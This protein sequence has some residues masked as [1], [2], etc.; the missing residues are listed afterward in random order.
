MKVADLVSRYS[1]WI[2]RRRIA[3]MGLVLGALLTLAS[4]AGR[5]GFDTDYRIWFEH[6]DPY[7]AQHDRFLKEFGN[8]DSFV[9]AFED[10][11]GVLRPPAIEAIQRLTDKLWHVRGVNRV[12]SLTNF[13]A[14]R[15]V[16]DGISVEDL[17]PAGPVT[18]EAIA[19]AQA[20]IDRDPLIVGSLV[21]KNR[22]VGVIRAKFAP[23][24][25]NP[26]LPAAVY[27]QL[28]ALLKEET[29]RSGY[30]FHIA[31]GPITDV[32]F[33]QVA[34]GDM[35]R[36]MPLLLLVM[37]CVLA[38]VFFSV[39]AVLIPVVVGLL[40]IVAVMGLNGLLGIK[41]D[42]VTAS[43]PQLLL[44]ISVA[45]VMHML[46]SFFE[47]KRQGSSSPDAARAAIDENATAML[48]TN[49]ATALG[50]ASFMVGNIV[51]VTRLGFMACVGSALITLLALTVVPALLSYYPRSAPRSPLLRL[52]LGSRFQRL[53]AWVCARPKRVIGTWVGAVV[54]AA[55]CM[56]LLVV[57]S[58]PTGYFKE[59]HWFRDSIDFM[60][61]RGSGGA[62]YEIVVRGKGPD[63]VKTVAYM[64]DLEA[65]TQ[66]LGH[67]APGDFRNVY[68]LSTIVRNLNRA[69]HED[70][71][72][73]HTVPT[74]N[75]EIA[76]YLLL[77]TLSVPVGQDIND[78]MNVDS[79]ASRITVIRPLVSTRVSRT[80]IDAIQA[81]AAKNLHEVKIEFTGRDVLYTNMGNNLTDS[82]VGSIAWDIAV[83]LP[84][85]LLMFRTVTASIVSVFAN[86][87]P[88]VI[89]M[90]F[91]ALAHINL[92]VGTLMVAGLG[93]GIAVDDTVHLLA[94]YYRYR[95]TGAPARE[96]AIGTMSHVGMPATLTTITL[97]LSF[98]V[99]S[100]AEFLP[101]LYFGL[102][103]SMVI[104]LALLAD[105]TLTPALL[106][107]I[108]GRRDAAQRAAQPSA[109]SEPTPA[110]PGAQPA[111]SALSA[112]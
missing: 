14:A 55:A 103:I 64:R 109:A 42:S 88:L 62:V 2:I 10:E 43:L 94:H 61:E 69:L 73:F 5:I 104:A 29:A 51:P 19:R 79:S 102:L 7:L 45:T 75:E 39:W 106:S 24:A 3:V 6:D 99:F 46:A 92:D 63:A 67:E 96:A 18:P 111:A 33:D 16:S 4:F 101:N 58:N 13:Q 59:H 27:T 93:L 28:T 100:G 83:I 107:W 97:A 52:D 78:R 85:L 77:Y 71:N 81:W 68:S 30:R 1:S 91:M 36:L 37:V 80:N 112:D 50:F 44:G 70:D 22:K 47:F 38:V 17:F 12:D 90:G 31:G 98:L 21:S 66:Y 65:L 76:Q 110:L 20:Y 105:L 74:T 9:V 32:A 82:M 35:G 11:Q 60:Q 8:D 48:L 15:A 40:S 25:I 41:L 54:L 49:L 23:N 86:V 72:S 108:D 87:G 26:D 57:D 84:L 95:G 89:V 34:R 56:P 53:G